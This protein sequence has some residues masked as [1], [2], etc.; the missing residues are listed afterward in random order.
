VCTASC[1]AD[2]PLE[3]SGI[4]RNVL[5]HVGFGCWLFVEPVCKRWHAEYRA[6]A[7]E[8]LVK[9][10][11]DLD[12]NHRFCQKHAADCATLTYWRAAFASA[13]ALQ[14]ATACGLHLN[15]DVNDAGAA[16]DAEP[17]RW[18]FSDEWRLDLL[19]KQLGKFCNRDLLLYAHQQH[20][21]PWSDWISAGAA[22]SGDLAKL[23]WLRK[24][25]QCPWS[26]GSHNWM[27]ADRN[28]AVCAQASDNALTMLRWLKGEGVALPSSTL[29]IHA[30]AAGRLSTLQFL[31][32]D[33]YT[34]ESEL[35]CDNAALNGHLEVLQWLY[36]QGAPLGDEIG[37][38]AAESA[39]V[40]VLIWL[41]EVLPVF[42]SVQQLTFMLQVA[43][44]YGSLEACIWL[45]QQGAEWPDVLDADRGPHAVWKQCVLDWARAEGC[46]TEH[47]GFDECDSEFPKVRGIISFWG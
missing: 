45:R 28:I 33:G 29:A 40:P 10:D 8:E 19:H 17:Y 24:E 21:V 20:N 12:C 41:A 25:Q 44:C 22:E 14:M 15:N 16:D 26:L 7:D 4:L 47:P 42:W 23:Q 39:S 18:H 32:A 34:F 2:N 11:R 13:E 5:S 36:K 1:E 27:T 9:H 46:T 37:D 3:H 43:G 38:H 6:L 35:P 31:A 30:A